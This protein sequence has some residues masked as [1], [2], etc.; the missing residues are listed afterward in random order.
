M[1][2]A[3]AALAGCRVE[4]AK[5]PG[6]GADSTA[7]AA[8]AMPGG[9]GHTVFNRRRE[10]V[11][12]GLARVTLSAIVRLDIGQDSARKVLESL[13][14]AERRSDSAA[15]AIRVLAYLPPAQGH[16]T[17]QRMSLI[18]LAFTDWAPEPGFDSLSVATKGHPYRTSTHFVHDAA[19]LR[20][21]MAPGGADSGASQLPR[22][23]LPPGH[24]A[25]RVP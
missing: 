8:G 16:G 12:P 24:P 21:M 6:A 9:L 1:A 11:A 10:L 2:L 20:G 25:P 19:T 13:V 4:G 23:T 22:G 18:P 7:A 3:L 14:A 5:Q 15:A 17:A